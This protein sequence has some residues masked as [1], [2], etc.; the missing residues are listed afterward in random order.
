MGRRAGPALAVLRSDDDVAALVGLLERLRQPVVELP[1]HLGGLLDGCRLGSRRCVEEGGG[2]GGAAGAITSEDGRVRPCAHGEPLGAATDSFARLA[3]A[4]RARADEAAAARG[5]ATCPAAA[6][7]SRCLFPAALGAGYCDFMR[8]HRAELPALHRYLAVAE[9]LDRVGWLAR[10]ARLKQRR[11]VPLIAA[12]G[13]PP[14]TR[15]RP[16]DA[17]LERSAAAVLEGYR[18]RGAWLVATATGHALQLP[19]GARSWLCPLSATTAA[20]AEL[21]DDGQSAAEL[22]AYLVAQ[23]L[24]AALGPELGRLAAALE[25]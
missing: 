7:C 12:R 21:L 18:A 10:P 19:D 25:L 8:A 20:V 24:G 16:A 4:V 6:V 11:A 14:P 5:C 22:E 3:A 9:H 23:H 15:A 17:G 2:A 13:R 1:P